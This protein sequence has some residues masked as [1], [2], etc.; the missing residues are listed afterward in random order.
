MPMTERDRNIRVNQ[1]Q[2]Q[3]QWLLWKYPTL[4]YK[5]AG[6]EKRHRFLR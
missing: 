5:K 1:T 2:S 4:V 6:V 3:D